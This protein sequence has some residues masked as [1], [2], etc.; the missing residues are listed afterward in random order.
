MTISQKPEDPKRD[1]NAGKNSISPFEDPMFQK[2][3]KDLLKA[4]GKISAKKPSR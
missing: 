4:P 3:V 2:V 1:S